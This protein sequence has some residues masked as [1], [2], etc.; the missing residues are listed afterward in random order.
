M[1][2]NVPGEL[3]SQLRIAALQRGVSMNAMLIEKLKKNETLFGRL[4]DEEQQAFKDVGKLNCVFWEYS[5]K[6]SWSQ[7][8]SWDE[9]FFNKGL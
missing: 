7:S 8:L 2:R 3:H 9:D 4:S 6:G 5:G 1:I